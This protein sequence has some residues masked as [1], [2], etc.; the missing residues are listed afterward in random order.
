MQ[1]ISLLWACGG[2]KKA[3]QPDLLQRFVEEAD[4]L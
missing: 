1:V 4:E 3:S 2:R